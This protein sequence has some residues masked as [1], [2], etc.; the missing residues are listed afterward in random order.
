MS[1]ILATHRTG[2]C[3]V[4]LDRDGTINR[5]VNYLS[6]PKDLRLLPGVADAIRRLNEADYAVVVVTNQSGVARGYFDEDTLKTI[7]D[8]LRARLAKRGAIIDAVYY[9]PHHVD[10]NAPYD[11]ACD[12][13]K[14]G[15]GMLHKAVRELGIR[16]VGSYVVGD[17]ERDVE[18]AKDTPLRSVLLKPRRATP[19]ETCADL[20]TTTLTKAVDWILDDATKQRQRERRSKQTDSA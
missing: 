9:C 16:V 15:K 5:E 1:E 8:Q 19:D 14:P 4:F 13:R 2:R 10:G 12:H 3:A 6:T 17:N 7:H 18:L 20:V 11:I